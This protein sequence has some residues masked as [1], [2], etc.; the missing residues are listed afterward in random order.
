MGNRWDDS[1]HQIELLNGSGRYLNV[2]KTFELNLNLIWNNGMYLGAVGSSQIWLIISYGNQIIYS[3]L[4]ASEAV[5]TLFTT[6][7]SPYC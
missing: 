1:L 7:I 4:S 3:I 6:G 2:G 5:Q